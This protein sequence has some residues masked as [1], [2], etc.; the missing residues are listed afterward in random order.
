MVK[1]RRVTD[2]SERDESDSSS[3]HRSRSANHVT[4]D[5]RQEERSGPSENRLDRMERILEGMLTHVTR[6]E[7]P[8]HTTHVLDQYRQQRP[9]V[10]KEKAKDDPCMVKFW[11]E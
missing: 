3:S 1:T 8:R 2:L 7:L 9:Q 5:G 11:M 4:S 10:F 6:N